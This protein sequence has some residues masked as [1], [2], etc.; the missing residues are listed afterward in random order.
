MLSGMKIFLRFFK[1]AKA[2][3][4]GVF[5][6]DLTNPRSKY[7]KFL[8]FRKKIKTFNWLGPIKCTVN[9]EITKFLGATES[10]KDCDSS[11][12]FDV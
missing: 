10:G 9:T 5:A 12:I 1:R 4:A 11:N 3:K 7:S 2:S 6:S 8:Q